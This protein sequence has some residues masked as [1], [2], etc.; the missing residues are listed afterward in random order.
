MKGGDHMDPRDDYL[1]LETR[2]QFFGRTA[3]G[4]GAVSRE[5][6][7]VDDVAAAATTIMQV[8]EGKAGGHRD[9]VTVNAAAA[10]WVAGV[11]DSV[12]AG[13][14]MAQAAIDSGRASGVLDALRE[15][16]RAE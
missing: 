9:I 7:I 11:C 14:P 1:K 13:V 3:M 8:F 12:E 15:R 10:L 4:L 5:A 2:R 16:S 6:L